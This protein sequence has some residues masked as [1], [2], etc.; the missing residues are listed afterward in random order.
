[1]TAISESGD[2][3]KNELLRRFNREKKPPISQ[4]VPAAV[5]TADELLSAAQAREERRTRRAEADRIRK[6]AR[7]KAKE[8][9]ERAHYLDQLDMRQEAVWNEVIGY[10]QQRQQK[11]YD[12]A[13]HLL[14]DL[15][16]IAIREGRETEFRAKIEDLRVKHATKRSFIERLIK[17][18]I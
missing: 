9:A 10:I 17:A 14:I 12:Q 7:G 16:D 1:M 13:I 4:A 6:E 3:W 11:G 2:R 18:N 5:R 15:R 8:E